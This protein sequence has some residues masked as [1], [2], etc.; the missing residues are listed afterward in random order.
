MS[1][2]KERI[3]EIIRG[4]HLS[5]FA[6]ITEDG[7]P[8]V[9]YVTARASEDLTIRFA[10]PKNTRKVAH[11]QKNPAVHLTSGVSDPKTAIASLQIEGSAEFVTEK[12]ELEAF[13]HD[14]LKIYFTGPDDPN[15]GVVVV[16]PSRIEYNSA[17]EHKTEVWEG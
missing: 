16:K 8:W 4:P 17:K 3:F 1:D 10:T 12:A 11:I 15:Y 9:R 14:M 2:L 7:K 13:W 5:S 6:T